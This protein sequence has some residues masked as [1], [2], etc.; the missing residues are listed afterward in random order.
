MP[1]L[2]TGFPVHNNQTNRILFQRKFEKEQKS[3]SSKFLHDIIF[4]KILPS[5]YFI[6]VIYNCLHRSSSRTLLYW[7]WHKVVETKH[8]RSNSSHPQE[9]YLNA[10]EATYSFS[11]YASNSISCKEEKTM[12]K[13]EK[14]HK[15]TDWLIIQ[16]LFRLVC[17]AHK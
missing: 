10:F 6:F 4:F 5:E 13:K 1:N 9:E 11:G 8:L 17:E 3:F 15:T 16:E 14:Q 12:P 7:F 2:F